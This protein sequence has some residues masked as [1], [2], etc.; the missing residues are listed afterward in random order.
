MHDPLVVAFTIRRPWP[1]RD[2][3][4]DAKDGRPRWEFRYSWATWRTFWKPSTYKAF[5]TVAGIGFYWPSI[6]TIWHVEPKGRDSGEV[7]RHVRRE[8]LPDGTW[9]VTALHGWKWH[10]HH[11]KIQVIPLQQFRRWLLTRCEWCGGRSRKGDY[12]NCS[13]SWD[14]QRSPWWRGERGLFH[15]DCSSIQQ[16]HRTCVCLDPIFDTELAGVGYGTCLRC[17]KRRAWRKAGQDDG[18]RATR[19]LAAVPSGKRS[20]SATQRATQIWREIRER[21]RE[22]AAEAAQ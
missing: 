22:N 4:R 20:R 8:Q 2:R 11:W 15:A 14:G 19:I 7:C 6:I 17:E 5:W 13:M 10:V 9:K 21:E 18:I 3:Y 16:A 12:V 1:Q